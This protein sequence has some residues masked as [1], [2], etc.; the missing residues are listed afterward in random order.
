MTDMKELWIAEFDRLYDEA[1]EDGKTNE[2][3][4]RWAE[5]NVQDA[6]ANRIGDMIDDARMRAKDHE[7]RMGN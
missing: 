3:A 6:Y 2:D 4:A 1:L 5:D 7:A